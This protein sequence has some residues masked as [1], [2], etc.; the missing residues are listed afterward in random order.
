MSPRNL[1]RALIHGHGSLRAFCTSR[2][3][4]VDTLDISNVTL[5]STGASSRARVRIGAVAVVVVMVAAVVQLLLNRRRQPVQL[6]GQV[7][8]R[9][10]VLGGRLGLLTGAG[11]LDGDGAR[12]VDELWK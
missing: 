5:T 11:P 1:F 8:E 4:A 10:R 6:L 3:F 9:R 12:V 7:S 2:T